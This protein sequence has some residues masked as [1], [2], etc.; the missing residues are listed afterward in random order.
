MKQN[1]K[2]LVMVVAALLMA[3]NVWADGQVNIVT[4]LNGVADA[5]AG[6][7]AYQVYETNGDCVLTVTPAAGNYITAADITVE[8]TVSGGVAQAPHRAPDL[9]NMLTLTPAETNGDPSGVTMYTF[10]MPDMDYDV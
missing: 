1:V 2:A 10:H 3:A 6:T 7:V 4:K 5:A 8:K 9:S